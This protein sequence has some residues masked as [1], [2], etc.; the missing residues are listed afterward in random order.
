MTA[1]ETLYY[2]TGVQDCAN[3]F[4]GDEVPSIEDLS[5]TADTMRL[6][7]L[8]DGATIADADA[9]AAAWIAGWRTQAAREVARYAAMRRDD[10][11]E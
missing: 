1:L 8:A 2:R 9:C 11:D 3:T 6:D 7:A 10:A 5:E 4:D